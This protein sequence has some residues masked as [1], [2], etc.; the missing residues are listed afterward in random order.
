MSGE[1]HEW[2]SPLE[3]LEGRKPPE[4]HRSEISSEALEWAKRLL[5][6][7]APEGGETDPEANK[8]L[9]LIHI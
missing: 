8:D 6:E 1:F 9:S 7:N 2:K 3:G 5:E 4:E